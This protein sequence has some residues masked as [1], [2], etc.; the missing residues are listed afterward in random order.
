MAELRKDPLV[1]RW[2]II[3]DK[4]GKRPSDFKA[5]KSTEDVRP[6]PCAFCPGYEEGTGPETFA[7]RDGGEANASDWRVRVIVNKFPAVAPD[8]PCAD[9]AVGE[10]T[11][12]GECRLPGFGSHEVVIET[13]DHDTPFVDLPVPHI[14]DVLKAY[15]VRMKSFRKDARFKYCQVFKNRGN[16]AGASMTHSHS[17]VLALPI[18]THNIEDELRGAKEY[19]DTH[20]RCIFCDVVAH[21]SAIKTR[22]IDENEHFVTAAPYAPRFP[23]ETW[24][25][26]KRHSSNYE[27]VGDDELQSL[28][29]LLKFMLQKMDVAFSQP[30]YNFMIQTAPLDPDNWDLPYYHWYVRLVPQL[31]TLGGF[32]LGSGCH[33][34]AVAPEKAAEFLRNVKIN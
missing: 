17:Q 13:P 3:S 1:Q 25:V 26:P 20:G 15:Q 33:I 30:P 23:Y 21:E 12:F 8:F 6:G 11:V 28:A 10:G 32:E 34:N 22:L 2:V 29:A 27:T 24:L 14:C 9:S 31:I 5:A 18:A 4:R 7:M 19:Y 16:R